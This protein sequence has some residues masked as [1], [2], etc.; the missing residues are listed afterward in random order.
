MSLVLF[1]VIMVFH[2]INDQ[3]VVKSLF[4]V[5]G[6][7]YGPLLGLFSFGLFTKLQVKDKYVPLICL[8]S[9]VICYFLNLYI[10]FGFELLIFNG[11]I[12]FFGL[13]MISTNKSV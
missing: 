3:S 2:A 13:Y 12:T 4:T 7:T 10:S 9:P 5:A 8:A 6:Y 11:V 1:S